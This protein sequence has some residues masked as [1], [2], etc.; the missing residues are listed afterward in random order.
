[1][2][3][4]KYMIARILNDEKIKLNMNDYME[5]KFPKEFEIAT[6]IC[7]KVGSNLKRNVDDA[8]IGYLAM[9]IE[10]VISGELD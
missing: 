10:R 4:V 8:E 1:M 3:H 7:N 5:V 6:I 9:H 2:N